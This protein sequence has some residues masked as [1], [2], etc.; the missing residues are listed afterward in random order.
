[1]QTQL[2][3]ETA[4]PPRDSLRQPILATLESFI[5]QRPALEPRNYIRSWDDRAGR[6]AYRADSRKITQQLNDAR[7]MLRY[8]EARPSI[9]GEDLQN[10]LCYRLTYTS[11]RGLDYTTCQYWPTEYRAAACRALASAIWHDLRDDASD[12]D[13]IRK[14]A[15]RALGRSIA[16]RWFR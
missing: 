16:G 4:A 5:N 6:A 1:V 10:A 8:V 2:S 14:A 11:G 13:S 7:A 12:G 15:R 9:T 3:N